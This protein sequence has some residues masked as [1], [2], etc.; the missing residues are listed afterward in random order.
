[1]GAPALTPANQKSIDEWAAKQRA[2]TEA[3]YQ[4]AVAEQ[5]RAK[6][7]ALP[8]DGELAELAQKM[9]KVNNAV[10]AQG[11]AVPGFNLVAELQRREV[12]Q[13][14]AQAQQWEAQA[15]QDELA[16]QKALAD[17]LRPQMATR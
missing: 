5:L 14:D 1:M 17:A 15:K 9:N 10:A 7:T 6:R 11:P 3:L 13:N 16:K 8:S 2:D 4:Q 12:P